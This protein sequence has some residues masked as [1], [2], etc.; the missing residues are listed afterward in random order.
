MTIT[1]EIDGTKYHCETPEEAQG[2]TRLLNAE[3]CLLDVTAFNKREG[4]MNLFPRT[5]HDSIQRHQE[6][7]DTI[8]HLIHN[9]Y[10]ISKE[11][12]LLTPRL[13]YR[14]VND[15]LTQLKRVGLL[16]AYWFKDREELRQLIIR[17]LGSTLDCNVCYE[18]T[19]EGRYYT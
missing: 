8:N 5:A 2:L 19:E 14:Q 1:L 9:Q 3:G 11:V 12:H 7:L 16:E 6:V 18:V 15:S 10:F 4:L 13:T 17:R